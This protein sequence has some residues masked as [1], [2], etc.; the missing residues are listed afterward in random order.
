MSWPILSVTTF[1]PIAGALFIM[2]MRGDGEAEKRNARW[3][4]LWTTLITFAISLILVYRFDPSSPEFQFVEKRPWLAG[5]LDP[6]PQCGAAARAEPVTREAVLD[7]FRRV[8]DLRQLRQFDVAEDVDLF[9][10]E[11]NRAFVLMQYFG[12][13]KRNPDEANDPDYTGYDFWLT[14]LNQ[15]NGNFVGAEM[16]KAFISSAEYRTRF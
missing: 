10:A 2:M 4:A 13:L 6:G 5:F 3:I 9:N 16:V 15:F 8:E 7:P 12:Y 11:F 1:L 14:K